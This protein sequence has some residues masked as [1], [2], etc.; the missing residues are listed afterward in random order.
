MQYRPYQQLL[1]D[2]IIAAWQS[3]NQRVAAE[4]PT[5]SGKTVVISNVIKQ[6]NVPTI[7]VAHRQELV[8]QLSMSL[9]RNDISHS[10][11]GNRN[12]VR[13]CNQLHLREFKKSFYDPASTVKVASIDTLTSK[14]TMPMCEKWAYKIGL[15]VMD[16]GHHL[17]RD[18][19]WGRGVNLFPKALGLGVSAWFGRTDGMG[20]GS[21]A[22]GF[23][24][25]IV[26]GPTMG[27]LIQQGHLSQFKTY[28][29]PS[30]IDTTGLNV[31]AVTGDFNFKSGAGLKR[32]DNV[33]S[34]IVGDIVEHYRRFA[35]G[36]L[37]VTFVTDLKTA[38]ET[39]EK[40]NSA[41]VP[42][43]AIDGN[44]PAKDRNEYLT[45]FANR[46]IMQI[47]NVDILGEGFDCPAIE[48]VSFARPTASY[49]LYIQQFGRALRTLEGKEFAVIIDHV[50]N[51]IKHSG[52]PVILKPSGLDR[53]EKKTSS[54]KDPN[55]LKL[56]TCKKCL[57]HYEQFMTACP[58][59]GD[60]NAPIE[61]QGPEQV[62]GDL[63]LMDS[64]MM[65]D[66]RTA[67]DDTLLQPSHPNDR[68]QSSLVKTHCE[69]IQALKKF[70]RVSALWAGKH[71]GEGRTL[72]E[73]NKMY[74]LTFRVDVMTAQTYK[75]KELDEL[76]K[77]VEGTL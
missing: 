70:Q 54:K 63:I 4:S 13:L 73:L 51:I 3:G 15:W 36:K 64:Y 76:T 11:I 26:R 74:Y 77:M 68:I 17:L 21:H 72:R 66:I 27:D 16:E 23:Y 39:A 58:Y 14:R 62:E 38:Y 47:V 5:G 19:K 29:P 57:G 45:K 43:V 7:A 30:R 2:E 32:V 37:G 22:D 25:H 69:K 67:I 18:N 31:S 6:L 52:P 61:V 12:V 71:K 60:E 8:T 55:E 1:H 48:C 10:V 44:T 34:Q 49:S 24:D 35:S 75:R 20:L 50:S 9:A 41:G 56:K 33:R 53:R 59:C 46:E 42:A 65:D 28:G 40:F